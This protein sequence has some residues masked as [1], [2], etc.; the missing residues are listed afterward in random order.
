[1]RKSECGMRNGELG[2]GEFG[3]RKSEWFEWG[4]RNAECGKEKMKVGE[5]NAK[6]GP[7]VVRVEKGYGAASMGNS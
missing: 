7:A 6:F 1:M 5:L 2:N 3:M 4:S